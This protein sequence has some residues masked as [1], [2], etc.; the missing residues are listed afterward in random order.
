MPKFLSSSYLFI[1]IL[2]LAASLR[3]YELDWDQNQHLHPDERFITMVTVAIEKP[4][5]LVEYFSTSTS[6]LNPHNQNFP[7][8][9]YGTFPLFLIKTLSD[10]T[11]LSDYNQITILGRFISALFDLSTV[12]LIY[13]IGRRVFSLSAG[14]L[15]AFFYSVSVLPIQL[16]HFYAVDTFLNFFLTLTLFLLIKSFY[17]PGFIL[18]IISGI[19]YGLAFASKVSAFLLIP[20][21]L[22]IF[23]SFLWRHRKK[24]FLWGGL[25]FLI[26]FF[27]FRITQPYAFL[28]PSFLDISLNPKFVANLKEL[29][30]FSQPGSTFPP[31]VQWNN[32]TPILYP[33]REIFFWGMGIPSA[34]I[35]FAA[36]VFFITR[37]PNFLI[38]RD[39]PALMLIIIIA[40]ILIY[41]GLQFAKPLRYFFPMYPSLTIIVGYFWVEITKNIQSKVKYIST[42]FLLIAWAI[43]PLT[44]ISIYTRPQTKILA[45]EWIYKNIP[46]GSTI[47]AEHWDDPLPLNL[48][49]DSIGNYK[50]IEFPL[51]NPDTAEKWTLLN[52]KI[53]E[54][55]YIILSSNK[56][57]GSI[58]RNPQMYPLTSKYY[59][60]LF[61]G[62]LGFKKVAQF[63]SRPSI[64][65]P[66]IKL[67]INLPLED[68]G[69]VA[70]K[71]QEC[72]QEG[73]IIVDDYVDEINTVYEHPKVIIFKKI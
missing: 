45:S 68:Y 23:L 6:P 9:V 55:D 30:S 29:Q 52:Q 46:A 11:G 1:L 61:D 24:V 7:F 3:F 47:S 27:T 65:I 15:A 36:I 69:G 28:G 18:F 58:T 17:S 10:I 64:P 26:S 31:A 37:I 48:D 71:I 40:T 56:L 67:C 43:W 39:Y 53:R 21:I 51:Y 22:I 72:N 44:F 16:S 12:L 50:I 42:T 13:L 66:G 73:I 19:S 5:S 41:Q 57:Y 8:F 25:F 59:Y 49:K 62:S 38:K 33:L 35:S 14:L 32:T 70:K 60:A 20:F 63:T 34:M 4:T 54:V 2:I